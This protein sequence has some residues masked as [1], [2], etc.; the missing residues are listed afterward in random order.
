MLAPSRER[1]RLVEED[2]MVGMPSV[3]MAGRFSDADI[4]EVTLAGWLRPPDSPTA[5]LPTRVGPARCWRLRAI[6]VVAMP[7]A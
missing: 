6:A 5:A 3:S 2:A 7:G 1:F 4:A